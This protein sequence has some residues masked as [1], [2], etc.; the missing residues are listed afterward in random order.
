ML[1]VVPSTSYG[2][3]NPPGCCAVSVEV[4]IYFVTG[5][6][7][8]VAEGQ[9][10][11]SCPLKSVVVCPGPVVLETAVTDAG[12][13]GIVVNKTGDEAT[14]AFDCPLTFVA[15]TV[16]VPVAFC[17]IPTIVIGEVAPISKNVPSTPQSKVTL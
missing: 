2:E 1:V 12:A 7:P 13:A 3:V 5:F 6:P 14:D 11:T 15:F 4:I 17:G 8:E 16:A 10:T 9:E